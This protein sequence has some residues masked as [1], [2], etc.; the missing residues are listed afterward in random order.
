MCSQ[1]K[2]I[3]YLSHFEIALAEL[4]R[5]RNFQRTSVRL[6]LEKKPIKLNARFLRHLRPLRDFRADSLIGVESLQVNTDF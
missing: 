3:V 4:W 6:E 2:R 5:E 1:G